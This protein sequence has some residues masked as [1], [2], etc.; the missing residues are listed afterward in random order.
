MQQQ[1]LDGSLALPSTHECSPFSAVL[2][3]KYSTK[4]SAKCPEHAGKGQFEMSGCH[5][6]SNVVTAV[7]ARPSH[8]TPHQVMAPAPVLL[9]SRQRKDPSAVMALHSLLQPSSCKGGEMLSVFAA[10]SES[11][12][13]SVSPKLGLQLYKPYMSGGK[14]LARCPR[15]LLCMSC[16]LVKSCAGGLHVCSP[17]LRQA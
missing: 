14:G 11:L 17:L 12:Q 13:G 15:S 16:T 3:L 10:L 5:R 7:F 6:C 4:P 1:M 9:R 2:K 8:Q